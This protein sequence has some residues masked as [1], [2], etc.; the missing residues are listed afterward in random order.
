MATNKK[1]MPAKKTMKAG[2]AVTTAATARTGKAK[3]KTARAAG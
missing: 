2:A 3:A 1:K